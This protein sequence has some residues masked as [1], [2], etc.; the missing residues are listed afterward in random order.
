MFAETCF[1]FARRIGDVVGRNPRLQYAG[2]GGLA[3]R[4]DCVDVVSSL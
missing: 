3:K 1:V 2:R 4:K